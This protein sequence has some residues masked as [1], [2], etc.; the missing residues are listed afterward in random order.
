MVGARV[1]ARVRHRAVERFAARGA[2]GQ[3]WWWC[4]CYP[5]AALLPLLPHA[6]RTSSQFILV[7]LSAKSESSMLE[8]RRPAMNTCSAQ[9]QRSPRC[10]C[11]SALETGRVQVCSRHVRAHAL[12]ST[13]PTCRHAEPLEQQLH[14][15]SSHDPHPIAAVARTLSA[16]SLSSACCRIIF[17]CLLISARPAR[18]ATRTLRVRLAAGRIDR[19]AGDRRPPVGTWLRSM[20]VACE[21]AAMG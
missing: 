16:G 11:G 12:C 14:A 18:A 4:C 5:A 13:H 2:Q 3:W 17:S 19:G 8:P 9:Q 15:L 7:E 1:G 20:L 6:P 21:G 10:A